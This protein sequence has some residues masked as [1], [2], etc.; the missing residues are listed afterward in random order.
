MCNDNLQ[1]SPRDKDL[2]SNK[3]QTK[4]ESSMSCSLSSEYWNA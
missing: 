3:P 2:N 1:E 4:D